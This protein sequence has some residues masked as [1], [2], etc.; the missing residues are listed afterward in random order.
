MIWKF[1]KHRWKDCYE[2][3]NDPKDEPYI[4]KSTKYSNLCASIFTF[5]LYWIAI[6]AVF[7]AIITTV[8]TVIGGVTEVVESLTSKPSSPS[9]ESEKVRFIDSAETVD[10]PAVVPTQP[11]DYELE[12]TRQ[13][14]IDDSLETLRKKA[15]YK[16][17][18]EEI[19]RLNDELNN[20]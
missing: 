20:E 3:F 1:I 8:I 5:I 6:P 15:E 11:S 7:Y 18:V 13:H 12:R 17:K 4:S 14:I 10:T 2:Y 16:E 19:H 9:L